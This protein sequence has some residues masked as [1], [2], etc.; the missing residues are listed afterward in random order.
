MEAA[1]LLALISHDPD[2]LKILEE[3]YK[4]ADREL[5]ERILEGMGSIGSS[6]SIPFLVQ[7]L[8]SQH[9]VTRLIAAS[10]LLHC[11]N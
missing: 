3:G 11:L 1:L 10:S 6:E 9:A 7:E 4:K 2:V 8:L 5:K